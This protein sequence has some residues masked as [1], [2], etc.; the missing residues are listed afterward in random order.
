M[1]LTVA[2]HLVRTP[3]EGRAKRQVKMFGG[4][5]VDHKL[6]PCRL[7]HRQV[8][9]PGT[10]Q[11]PIHMVGST[12]VQRRTTRAIEHQ[13]PS[14][15]P[16]PPIGVHSREPVLGRKR[17]TACALRKDQCAKYASA[18]MVHLFPIIS[19]RKRSKQ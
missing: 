1:L 5:E 12:P 8:G 19:E 7:L 2:E 6:A 9:R 14:L 3:Q 18:S 13:A 11:N 10:F 4:C 15:Y 16:F 17:H